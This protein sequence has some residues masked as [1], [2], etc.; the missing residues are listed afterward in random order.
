MTIL[1]SS[2]TPFIPLLQGGGGVHLKDLYQGKLTSWAARG[3]GKAGVL[4][5]SREAMRGRSGFHKTTTSWAYGFDVGT[6]T[7]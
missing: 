3:R 6:G 1:A 2:Y 7:A 4:G 5:G